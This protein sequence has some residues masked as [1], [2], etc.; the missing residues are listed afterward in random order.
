MGLV[1]QSQTIAGYNINPPTDDAANTDNNE[2][3]WDKHEAKLSGPVKTLTQQVNTEL[4]L[5]FGRIFL[6]GI[7]TQAT[8]Y[9]AQTSDR[10]KLISV[11]GTRTITLLASATATSGFVTAIVNAGSGIVTVDGSGA[12]TIDGDATITLLPK[13]SWIG[14]TDGVNYSSAVS[15]ASR[16]SLLPRGYLA[17]LQTSIGTDTDHDIDIA[18]GECRDAA[19]TADLAITSILTKQIDASWAAGSGAGGMANGVSLSTATWYNLFLVDTDA[20]GVDAGFDT[21][22][23]ATNLL[24][25][26]GVGTVYRR[27]GSVLTDSSS[28]IL[29]YVQVGDR[30]MWG[31]AAAD[32][33]VSN[34]STAAVSRTLSVPLGVKVDVRLL[35]FVDKVA[36]GIL[37]V[38]LS[39]L[40]QDDQAPN[41]S[42]FFTARSV[43]SNNDAGGQVEVM[44]NTSSQV[45]TR[46]TSAST[47]LNISTLGWRDDLGRSD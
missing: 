23:A 17:G 34:Q 14:V 12:E 26:S 16:I 19:D 5:A 3:V 47:V 18:V 29:A 27:I 2:V 7:N 35:L 38:Y 46:S 32:V 1:Y 37:A 24:A 6:N 28:N 9:T 30:F 25:T 39:S 33:S 10:G 36:G 41:T 11:T 40:D 4:L 22:I 45:R 8:N 43:G 44:S 15:P 21:D 13:E 42:T 31:A 20:G